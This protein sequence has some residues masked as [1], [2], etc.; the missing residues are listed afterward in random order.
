VAKSLPPARAVHRYSVVGSLAFGY[1]PDSRDVARSSQYLTIA[2]LHRTSYCQR[3]DRK[4]PSPASV[5]SRRNK[6]RAAGRVSPYFGREI[7]GR[8]DPVTVGQQASDDVG[9]DEARAACDKGWCLHRH[10]LFDLTNKLFTLKPGTNLTLLSGKAKKSPA[11]CQ[12]SPHADP[13]PVERG[14]FPTPSG[15]GC[16][17]A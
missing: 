17:A 3:H 15:R 5:R 16:H 10:Q 12:L 4:Q 13:L 6:N 9:S 8:A 2:I 14:M 7:I 11:S 1:L